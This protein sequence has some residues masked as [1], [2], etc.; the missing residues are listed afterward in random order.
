MNNKGGRAI[1]GA[2]G[3]CHESGAFSVFRSPLICIVL[4][5]RV[6]LMGML[7]RSNEVAQMST[8]ESKRRVLIVDDDFTNAELLTSILEKIYE[9]KS[10][11]NGADALECIRTEL[12]PDIILLDVMMPK[13]DGYE[14]CEQ[15][16]SDPKTADIP[17]IFISALHSPGDEARGLQLG[18]MDY[19]SKPII[20]AI[21]LLRIQT[22][23]ELKAHREELEELVAA[24][25]SQLKRAY[26]EL[27]ELDRLKSA[28][29]ESVSH[30]LRTPLTS[31]IGFAKVSSK[32]LS[33]SV[34]AELE[35]LQC[36]KGRK[37]VLQ[38]LDNLQH[39]AHQAEYLSKQVRNVM[40]FS[41]LVAENQMIATSPVPLEPLLRKTIASAGMAAK[42][43]HVRLKLEVEPDL[44]LVL[45]N[46]QR[47]EQ[48]LENLISNA[49][50][51]NGEDGE[52]YCQARQLGNEVVISIHDAG[53]G[54]PNEEQVRIFQHFQQLG[55]S[56][57]G[58]PKG[59][60]IGLSL[61]QVI[62]ERMQGRIWVSSKVGS[63]S[64][65]SVALRI[66]TGE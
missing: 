30:E 27:K 37:S 2:R 66:H 48:V 10:V 60:G 64:V 49:F 13:M 61:S 41:E 35:S 46:P 57:T 11:H 44:P 51:F 45:T 31:V 43:P 40:E 3:E 63:G 20:P 21:V 39:I 14:V 55:D 32:K 17:V 53:P 22:Q 47:L 15:L 50:K 6:N 16:K 56:V 65:F 59:L 7:H 4:P 26:D 28:L 9:V 29:L 33:S 24:K 8:I 54:I 1:G 18:A 58:K 42:S 38:V 36:E 25:T 52:V 19:I 62:M 34:L 23:L 12:H 5:H